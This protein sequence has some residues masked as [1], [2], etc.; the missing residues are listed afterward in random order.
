MALREMNAPR[1]MQREIG[2]SADRQAHNLKV[3]GS[4]PIPAT[5]AQQRKRPL[6]IEAAVVV[7][8]HDMGGAQRNAAQFEAGRR[9]VGHTITCIRQARTTTPV[10]ISVRSR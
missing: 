4:N 2:F 8:G 6:S 9:I 10:A 5:I 1:V 3:I 7:Y